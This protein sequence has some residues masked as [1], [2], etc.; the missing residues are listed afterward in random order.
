MRNIILNRIK[1]PDGTVLTS[2]HR[3]DYVSHIDEN[4]ETYITDGGNEY[5]RRSVNNIPAEELSVYDDEPFEV[6]RVSYHRGSRGK[7]GSSPLTWIPISEMSNQ[8]LQASIQ[9]NEERGDADC[10][11][12]KFYLMELEYRKNNNIFVE[13]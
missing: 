12:N 5:F 8:H 6:I 1:T 3:H 11:A 4:G 9:Y 7:D 2:H 13:E 10:Q